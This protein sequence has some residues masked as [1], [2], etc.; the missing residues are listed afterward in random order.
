MLIS[1]WHVSLRLAVFEKFA[2][3]GQN[4]GPK[5]P[6][7]HRPQKGKRPFPDRPVGPTILKNFTP[8]GVTVAD[9]CSHTKKNIH[10]IYQTKRILSI[11]RDGQNCSPIETISL[12]RQFSVRVATWSASRSEF[13]P[14]CKGYTHDGCSCWQYNVSSYV[15]TIVLYL[16]PVRNRF[17][18]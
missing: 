3:N 7:E 15:R 10:Q 13:S 5:I 18:V 4:L 6:W 9:I 1:I 12:R 2:V 8:I 16:H 17:I 11:K 14:L